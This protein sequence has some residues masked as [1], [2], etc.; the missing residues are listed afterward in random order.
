LRQRLPLIL[1]AIAL[2]VSLLGTSPLGQ[3]AGN[4][5]HAAVPLALFANDAGKLNGHTSSTAP[6]GGQ[7][8]VLDAGGKLPAG[9]RFDVSKVKVTLGPAVSLPVAET[10]TL[11]ATC[12]AGSFVVGGGYNVH[13]TEAGSPRVDAQQ[14]EP[15]TQAWQVEAYNVPLIDPA[16]GKIATHAGRARAFAVC[17]RP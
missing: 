2:V 5:V 11:T 17:V 13:L 9:I 10:T 7:I 12:A 1:S 8:P 14:P 6:K 3:A 4:A 16:T 15:Q